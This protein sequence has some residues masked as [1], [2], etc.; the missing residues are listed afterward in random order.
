[1]QKPCT[2]LHNPGNPGFSEAETTPERTARERLTDV[3]NALFDGGTK[4]PCLRGSG[5]AW[6][7]DD[8]EVRAEAVTACKPCPVLDLCH[9]VAVEEDHKFGVWAGIDRTKGTSRKKGAA[10]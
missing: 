4:V 1:M 6:T 3:L 9:A 8:P 5:D 2:T 10:K 7:D